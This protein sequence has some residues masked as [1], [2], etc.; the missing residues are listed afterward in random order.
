MDACKLMMMS[1]TANGKVFVCNGCNKYHLEYKNLQ[2]SFNESEYRF[3]VDYFN[4]I[5]ADYWESI[6][7]NTLYRK[8]IMVPIGHHNFTMMFDYVEILELRELFGQSETSLDT[9]QFLLSHF[10]LELCRN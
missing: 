10:N 8:K 4:K 5:D 1:Q 7:K 3:F 2:F 6:N 9:N